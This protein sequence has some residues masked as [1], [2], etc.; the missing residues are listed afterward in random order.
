[1]SG[2]TEHCYIVTK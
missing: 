1:M 2:V